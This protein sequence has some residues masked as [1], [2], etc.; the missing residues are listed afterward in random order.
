M[1][2][3]VALRAG[4]LG[5]L[6]ITAFVAVR[7]YG[8]PDL[9]ELR[10]QVQAAGAVGP[11]V[12]LLGYAVLTLFPTPKAV[13][14]IAG[15]ALFGLWGGAALALSGALLGSA[16]A[17]EIGRLVGWDTVSRFTGG[18]LD[19]LER[20][21]THHGFTAVLA[22]RLVPVIPFTLINYGSGVVG[23][24]RRQFLLGSALGMLPA[25]IA[26]AAVGAYGTDPLRLG[27][28]LAA[29]VALTVVAGY[30]GRRMLTAAERAEGP[31]PSPTEA[32]ER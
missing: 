24:T 8:L 32:V 26:Y 31:A 7:T 3:S 4:L 2:R 5:L 6:T 25:A 17:H 9:A 20:A 11:L 29:L 14:T 12:F 28:A 13:V 10:T 16:A 23:L 27:L 22:V 30:W 1:S 21:L 19:R 15:G 18:R